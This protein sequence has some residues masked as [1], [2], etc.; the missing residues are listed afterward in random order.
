MATKT[1]KLTAAVIAA[2]A[3]LAFGVPFAGAT[4]TT[5]DKASLRRRVRPS[6]SPTSATSIGERHRASAPDVDRR[7]FRLR[8]GQARA[9]TGRSAR[10]A[11]SFSFRS[12]SSRA[13]SSM[14]VRF[15]VSA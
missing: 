3:A 1:H 14:N 10:A 11:S 15:S 12:Y 4:P 2:V 8:R 6:R 13:I 5:F 7:G 9:T